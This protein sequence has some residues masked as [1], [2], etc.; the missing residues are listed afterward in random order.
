MSNWLDGLIQ[1]VV[2]NGSMSISRP[3]TSG[4]LQG[5]VLGSVLFN[6]FISDIDSWIKCALS[7]FTD[8]TKLSGPAGTPEGW[9]AIQKDLDKLEK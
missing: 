9:D 2:V 1:M 5:P 3:V 7:K 8:D 6:I 4:V